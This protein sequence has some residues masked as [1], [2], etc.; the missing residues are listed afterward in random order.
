MATLAILEA[1]I[2]GLDVLADDD[3]VLAIA[4]RAAFVQRWLAG[5]EGQAAAALE[6][7]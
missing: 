4:D 7:R 1:L 6:R 2:R 5:A 3:V